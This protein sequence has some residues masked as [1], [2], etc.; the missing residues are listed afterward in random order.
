MPKTEV[1]S[2]TGQAAMN[3]TEAI[4]KWKQA[5]SVDGGV[6]VGN[7]EPIERALRHCSGEGNEV[8]ET[9]PGI[10]RVTVNKPNARAPFDLVVA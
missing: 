2:K 6:R 1:T 8:V 4:A 10:I 3:K 5:A 7:W 9:S